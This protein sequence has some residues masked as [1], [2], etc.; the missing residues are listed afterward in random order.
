MIMNKKRLKIGIIFNFK[1]VWMGGIIYILNVIRMLDFLDD[2]DKPEII[3]FYRSD[4]KNLVNE[5]NYPYF[6]TY[7]WS[8]PSIKKG[9]IKSWLSC[10]NVFVKEILQ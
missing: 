7:E 3:L 5:I 6:V 8:F 10:K 9:Y 2:E 1:S 4:L